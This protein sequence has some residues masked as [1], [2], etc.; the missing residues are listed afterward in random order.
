MR[1][2]EMQV[3][4]ALD[5]KDPTQVRPAVLALATAMDVATST[6]DKIMKKAHSSLKQAQTAL[7]EVKADLESA[8]E[9]IKAVKAFRE[10][11]DGL[12]NRELKGHIVKRLELLKVIYGL[13]DNP[14]V[15]QRDVSDG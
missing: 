6:A 11:E 13:I 5:A 7:L 14:E 9:L 4:E 10:W 3:K 15:T 1:S 8:A 12:N 2:W